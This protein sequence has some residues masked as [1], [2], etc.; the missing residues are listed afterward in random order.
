MFS[1]APCKFLGEDILPAAGWLYG[2][3]DGYDVAVLYFSLVKTYDLT[4][5]MTGMTQITRQAETEQRFQSPVLF[6]VR[7]SSMTPRPKIDLAR[8]VN[9]SCYDTSHTC[10]MVAKRWFHHTARMGL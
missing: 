2:M 6:M 10:S 8:E 1:D 7:T 4:Q 5:K 9:I 3:H